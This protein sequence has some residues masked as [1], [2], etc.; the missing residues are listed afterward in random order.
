MKFR[1]NITT[2]L[3]GKRRP[4]AYNLL[5]QLHKNLQETFLKHMEL[6]RPRLLYEAN[7]S[8]SHFWVIFFFFSNHF[9]RTNIKND[10][11]VCPDLTVVMDKE[12]FEVL[13]RKINVIN[14]PFPSS[15]RNTYFLF[16]YYNNTASNLHIS[17][18]EVLPHNLSRVSWNFFCWNDVKSDDEHNKLSKKY[19]FLYQH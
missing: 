7:Y 5:L 14:Y 3:L 1:E 16:S 6:F 12:M 2:Y 4:D 17:F 8:F 18:K 13:R 9:Q 19:N 15:Y 11:T 10:K